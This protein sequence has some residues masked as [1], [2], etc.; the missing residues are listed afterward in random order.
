M[1]FW[2]HSAFQAA[3]HLGGTRGLAHQCCLQAGSSGARPPHTTPR[4]PRSDTHTTTGVPNQPPAV[5]IICKPWCIPRRLLAHNFDPV[6]RQAQALLTHFP[7]STRPRSQHAGILGMPQVR[8]REISASAASRLA[9]GNLQP[10]NILSAA[11]RH[12]LRWW[13]AEQS[14]CS[15]LRYEI[16]AIQ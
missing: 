16:G 11:P 8:E 4:P 7:P 12:R 13:L 1:T 3:P 6:C 9:G 2:W 10:P 15:T 5:S 14:Q